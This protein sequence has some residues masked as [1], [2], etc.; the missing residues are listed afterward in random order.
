MEAKNDQFGPFFAKSP[1]PWFG[2]RIERRVTSHSQLLKYI[3][4]NKSNAQVL[5]PIINRLNLFTMFY[6]TMDLLFLKLEMSNILEEK[7]PTWIWS[8]SRY[9]NFRNNIHSLPISSRMHLFE[10][11]TWIVWILIFKFLPPSTLLLSYSF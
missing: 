11:E 1:C 9:P 10:A 8:F 2:E 6:E 5:T 3:W 7:L 4:Q